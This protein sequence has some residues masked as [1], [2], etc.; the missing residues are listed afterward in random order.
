MSSVIVIVDSMAITNLIADI[1]RSSGGNTSNP[2]VRL[3]A[4]ENQ[5][6]VGQVLTSI[7]QQFNR[8][9]EENIAE[10]ISS[11]SRNHTLLSIVCSF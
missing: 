7:S 5:N 6:I 9:N 3:L 8:M 4:S 10:A 2:I 11:Q 1:Q